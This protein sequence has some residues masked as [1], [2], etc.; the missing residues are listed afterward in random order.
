MKKHF[1][2]V[3]TLLVLAGIASTLRLPRNPDLYDVTAA[4][5]FPVLVNGRVKPLDTVART[6]LLM[7]QGRQRVRTPD[8][9]TLAPIEWLLDVFYRPARADTYQT[10]EIVHPDLL[11]LLNLSP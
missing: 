11:S 1:P 4:S 7:I 8:G 2:L 9:V 10:F 3:V 5:H 6:S